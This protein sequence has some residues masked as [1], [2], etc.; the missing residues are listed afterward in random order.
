MPHSVPRRQM[1]VVTLCVLMAA[2][3]RGSTGGLPSPE[4][5]YKFLML[6]PASVP[7]HRNMFMALAEALVDRGHKVGPGVC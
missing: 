2:L 5:S 6:L 1:K 3:V 7:S 4:R